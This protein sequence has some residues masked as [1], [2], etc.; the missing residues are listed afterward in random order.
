MFIRPMAGETLAGEDG[1]DFALKIRRGR[2]G[3]SSSH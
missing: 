2:G 1:T 3:T